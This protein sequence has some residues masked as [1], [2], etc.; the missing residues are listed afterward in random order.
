MFKWMC[1]HGF[2]DR[3]WVRH[4]ESDLWKGTLKR[5]DRERCRVTKH[6]QHSLNIHV[7]CIYV[8]IIHV[9]SLQVAMRFIVIQCHT[10]S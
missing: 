3:S 7:T 10:N 5:D 4:G 6:V 8:Y 2:H 1:N 9:Q